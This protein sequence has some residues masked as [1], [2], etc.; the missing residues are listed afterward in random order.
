M[1][2]PLEALLYVCMY[3]YI[4]CESRWLV[5]PFSFIIFSSSLLFPPFCHSLPHAFLLV[6]VSRACLS[7]GE[8]RLF[9]LL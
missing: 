3:T 1:A 2:E 7:M 9:V 5:F 6:F 8:R 4:G